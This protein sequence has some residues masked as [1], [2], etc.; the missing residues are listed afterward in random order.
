MC[1]YPWVRLY[2]GARAYIHTRI[3]H[4]SRR[5]HARARRHARE[6]QGGSTHPAGGCAAVHT[7][8]MGVHTPPVPKPHSADLHMCGFAQCE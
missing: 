4:A 7:T 3:I 5:T 1:A 6:D 8:R 2:V